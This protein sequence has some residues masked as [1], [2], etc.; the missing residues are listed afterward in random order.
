M[1]GLRVRFVVGY[2]NLAA[3]DSTDAEVDAELAAHGDVVRVRHQE[4]YSSLTDKTMLFFS[5]FS[6][7][8]PADFYVKADDDIYLNLAE[9]AGLLRR[10][11]LSERVYIGCMKHGVVINDRRWGSASELG[12]CVNRILSRRGGVVS[13]P[14]YVCSL[15]FRPRWRK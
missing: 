8:Y 7:M 11:H 14:D 10:H 15:S 13:F 12:V 2:S 5:E 4:V 1:H 3:P 6:Q 9:L